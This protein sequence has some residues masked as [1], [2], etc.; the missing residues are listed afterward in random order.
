MIL[1][2]ICVKMQLFIILQ[3]ETSSC[4]VLFCGKLMREIREKHQRSATLG[5]FS[6]DD[7]NVVTFHCPER[8]IHGKE[9]IEI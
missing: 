1:S 4:F 7:G 8:R 9:I 5:Q 3:K 2:R 6:I